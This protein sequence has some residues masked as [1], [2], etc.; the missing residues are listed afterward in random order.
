MQFP[1]TALLA[2][3]TWFTTVLALALPS[4][5]S[6]NV[7]LEA[8]NAVIKRGLCTPTGPSVCNF[9][10]ENNEPTLSDIEQRVYIFN[11][12][13]DVIGYTSTPPSLP[14][15]L[16]SQLPYTVV[17]TALDRSFSPHIVFKYGGDNIDSNRGGCSC[18]SCSSGLDAYVEC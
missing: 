17:I 15:D 6:E 7:A 5:A 12:Y 13:C 11:R 4:P 18:S 2:S 16:Y 8:R 3:L 14:Y 10:V 9:G 1:K